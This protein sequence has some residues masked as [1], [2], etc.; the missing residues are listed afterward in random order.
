M[1]HTMNDFNSA[2]E[3]GT[4]IMNLW[5]IRDSPYVNGVSI[6]PS[7]LMTIVEI[8]I[9]KKILPIRI[10]ATLPLKKLS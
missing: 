7:N 3:T 2:P 4:I 6:L 5:G 8:D 1:L 9:R 10:T